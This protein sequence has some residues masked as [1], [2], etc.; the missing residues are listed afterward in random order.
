VDEKYLI[1][2]AAAVVATTI[3]RTGW[4]TVRK[5]RARTQPS[6]GMACLG[7]PGPAEQLGAN[8]CDVARAVLPDALADEQKMKRLTTFLT[9]TVIVP[10][11]LA[12]MVLILAGSI[13]WAM[14]L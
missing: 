9:R 11:L 10:A 13:A 4:R 14:Y 7:L 1:E 5:H 12:L 6:A 8:W 3:M 2:L